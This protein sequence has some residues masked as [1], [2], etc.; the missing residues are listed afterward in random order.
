ML[1]EKQKNSANYLNFCK[2]LLRV[3]TEEEIRLP[4]SLAL[5]R[6]PILKGG[7]CKIYYK[8]TREWTHISEQ[9]NINVKRLV[10]LC[11]KSFIFLERRLYLRIRMEILH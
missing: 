7:K 9:K 3:M 6:I 8:V 10:D 1:V 2:K 11:Q 5:F 4:L